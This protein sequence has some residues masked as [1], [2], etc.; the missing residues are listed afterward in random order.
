MHFTKSDVP[1]NIYKHANWHRTQKVQC[2]ERITDA[3]LS[4]NNPSN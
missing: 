1:S 3:S 2:T 4:S